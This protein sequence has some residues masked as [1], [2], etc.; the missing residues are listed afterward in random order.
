VSV[1]EIDAKSPTAVKAYLAQTEHQADDVRYGVVAYKV[2]Y[3]TVDERGRPNRASGLLVLPEGMRST[4]HAVVYGHGTTSYRKDVASAYADD[5]TVSPGVVFASRGFATLLPDYVG[6][7]DSPGPH[8]Y[9][10]LPTETSAAADML[11]AV[12][13]HLRAQGRPLAEKVFATGFSQGASTALGLGRALDRGEVPGHRLAALAAISGAY[14][15]RHHQLPAMAGGDVAAQIAVPYTAF[16]LVAWNRIYGIYH[17]PQ[18]VFHQPYAGVVDELFSSDT[19]GEEMMKTLPTAQQAL[20]TDSGRAQLTDPGPALGRALDEADSVCRGWVP[21]APIRLYFAQH[22][23]QVVPA[24]TSACEASFRAAGA[25]PA[26]VDL[27][28]PDRYESRHLGTQVAGTDD[29]AV[30]FAAQVKWD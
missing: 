19:T 10:H 16:L 30:W 3:R 6:L 5:F 8:P 23:E 24:N 27:G 20:L 12:G 22:D 26:V 1:T 2:V 11:T 13:N 14:S 18:D 25:E 29:A 15:L 7:G 9:L 4:L 17:N 21:S 28:R